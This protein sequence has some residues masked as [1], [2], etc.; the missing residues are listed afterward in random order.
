METLVLLSILLAGLGPIGEAANR[1]AIARVIDA[2][3]RNSPAGQVWS[4]TTAPSLAIRSVRFPTPDAALVE[5]VSTQYGSMILLRRSLVTIVMKRVGADW[6]IASL[7]S[8]L[9]CGQLCFGCPA[10]F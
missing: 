2:L 3:N 4:E 6:K 8:T 9:E 7:D 10:C 1:A 5:A